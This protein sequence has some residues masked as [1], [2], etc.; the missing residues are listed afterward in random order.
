MVRAKTV[1]N[2]VDDIPFFCCKVQK[3]IEIS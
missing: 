1:K 3:I 2:G